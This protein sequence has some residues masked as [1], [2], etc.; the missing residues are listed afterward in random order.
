MQA[1]KKKRYTQT[2]VAEMIGISLPT[3]IY[4]IRKGVVPEPIL[5]PGELRKHYTEAQYRAILA[6][7]GIEEED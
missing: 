3:L 1:A 5:A 6:M 4:R 2:H 7:Y